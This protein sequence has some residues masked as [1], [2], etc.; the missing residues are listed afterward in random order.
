[1]PCDPLRPLPRLC[2]A[3]SHDLPRSP[4]GRVL[5]R[6]GPSSSLPGRPDRLEPLAL[7][8]HDEPLPLRKIEVRDARRVDPEPRPVLFI[9]GKALETDHRVGD[10]VSPFARHE[11]AEERPSVRRNDREP[12]SRIALEQLALVRIDL[13]PN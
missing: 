6:P 1:M 3:G 7:L 13:V 2:C 8:A 5:K 4:A 9:G 11:I 10:V 12:G